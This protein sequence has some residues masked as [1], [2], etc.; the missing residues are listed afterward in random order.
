M[1]ALLSERR[2]HRGGGEADGGGGLIT[3]MP[4]K[5]FQEYGITLFKRGDR[6]SVLYDAGHLAGQLR[7]D[8]VTNEQATRLQ[9]GEQSAHAV[10]LE[11]VRTRQEN[12]AQ[13]IAPFA[14]SVGP[15]GRSRRA[16]TFRLRSLRELRSTRTELK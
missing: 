11:L 2:A 7:E 9:Q 15:Q 6:F 13:L 8:E 16:V 3:R 10:L 14:L 5:I 4:E 1:T 12:A